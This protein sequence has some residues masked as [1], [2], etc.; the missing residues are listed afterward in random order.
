MIAH[1]A[2]NNPNWSEVILAP[3]IQKFLDDLSWRLISS[4]LQN[5]F[6]IPQPSFAQYIKTGPANPKIP[7][8]FMSVADPLG[9]LEHSKLALNVDFVVRHEHLLHPKSGNLQEVSRE[10]VHIY[11]QE[12]PHYRISGA[13]NKKRLCVP[14]RAYSWEYLLSQ[15]ST[16]TLGQ[17]QICSAR[18]EVRRP[19][20]RCAWT[21]LER[22]LAAVRPCS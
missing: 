8:G 20:K 4:V 11:R 15:I 14:A 1:Q 19:P 22:V 13:K 12:P 18:G 3:Q 16:R 17:R 10:S 5:R 9:V 21:A 6:G 2:T 7:A